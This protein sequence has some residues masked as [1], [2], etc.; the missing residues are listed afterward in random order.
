MTV[1]KP[2]A[3]LFYLDGLRAIAILAVLAFHSDNTWLSGGFL[4]VEI[5]F[6]ISGFIITKLLLDEWQ[7]NG[8]LDLKRI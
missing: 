6:V 2:N 3:Y 8:R 4:G 7:K 1:T 5:F